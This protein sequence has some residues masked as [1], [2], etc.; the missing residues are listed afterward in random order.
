MSGSANVPGERLR[1][2]RER[3][4]FS[5]QKVAEDLHI[6]VWVV[7]ALESGRHASLGAPVYV[8][9]H[10]RKYAMLLGLDAEALVSACTEQQDPPL[11]MLRPATRVRRRPP[12]LPLKLLLIGLT[13]VVVA[14]AA[15][16]SYRTWRDR[17]QVSPAPAATSGVPTGASAVIAPA[18]AETSKPQE[19][20]QPPVTAGAIPL[21]GAERPAAVPPLAPST[22][23]MRVRLS[24]SADSWVE[25]YDASE[26]RVF[27]DLG[28]ANS[29]RS[30]T[31]EPP[32][33][34]FLGYADAVQVELDGA[35]LALSDEV[36]RGNV[37]HFTLDARG[38]MKPAGTLAGR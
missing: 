25:L 2:E 4:G 7:E 35:P 15:A 18:V 10:L 29:A 23:R 5:A 11:V 31:V 30:F 28:V 22:P 13:A 21:A 17:Q 36:R 19:A 8:K 14:A 33:R 20:L 32:A 9:G 3:R 16:W 24:F 6:D 26:R 34:M 1:A 12:R 37:A 27:F 38:R